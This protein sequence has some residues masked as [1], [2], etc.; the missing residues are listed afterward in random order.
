M[1]LFGVWGSGFG[2]WGL[3]SLGFRAFR[4][5]REFVE[6]V[7]FVEFMEFRLR[8]GIWGSQGVVQRVWG[9]MECRVRFEGF[10]V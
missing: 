1:E 8:V 4:E 5:F 6:F 9:Y 7:E 3:G 10:V 2:V